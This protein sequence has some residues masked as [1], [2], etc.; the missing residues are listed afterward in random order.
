MGW[1]ARERRGGARE[2][3]LNGPEGLQ[4]CGKVRQGQPLKPEETCRSKV[5]APTGARS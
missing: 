4:A 3:Y 5:E 1:A 2:C